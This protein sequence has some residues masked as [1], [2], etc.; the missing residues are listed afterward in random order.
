MKDTTFTKEIWIEQADAKAIA[1]AEAISGNLDITLM[2][3]GNA[4]IKEIKKNSDGNVTKLNGVLPPEGSVYKPTKLNV[5]WLPE[6]N[7]LAPLT[8][9]EF[10]YLLKKKKLDKNED[11]VD[12]VN[13]DSK[14]EIAAV[15]DSNM[16]ELKCG[17]ILQLERKGYYNG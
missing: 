10:G 9:V 15:G 2:D 12:V 14:K 6:I 8:L 16:R 5:T 13:R 1:D 7:E 17:D 11:F 3:W 4:S